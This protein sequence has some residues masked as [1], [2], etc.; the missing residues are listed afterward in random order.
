MKILNTDNKTDLLKSIFWQYDSAEKLKSLITQKQAYYDKALTAFW[1]NWYKNVF[2]LNTADT[3]GL[4]LWGFILNLPRQIK[5]K[6]GNVATLNDEQYRILLKGQFLKFKSGGTVPEINEYLKA[7]FGNLGEIYV[8]DNLD[9]SLTLFIGF[10]PPDWLLWLLENID[11]IP[12]PAGVELKFNI[13]PQNTLGFNGSGLETFNNGTFYYNYADDASET[14]NKIQFTINAPQSAEVS[15]NGVLLPYQNGYYSYLPLNT[16]YTLTV[17]RAGYQPYSVSGT[18]TTDMLFNV[19]D[20]QLRVYPQESTIKIDGVTVQTATALG[21][22]YR[23][24]Y[25]EKTSITVNYEASATNYGTKQGTQVLTVNEPN[26]LIELAASTSGI[27]WQ[28]DNIRTSGNGIDDLTSW[29]CDLGGTYKIDLQGEGGLFND[30]RNNTYT[31]GGGSVSFNLNLQIGQVLSF[32]KIN[33]GFTSGTVGFITYNFVD[34]F[35]GGAG[36][37]C[38]LDGNLIAVSGGG[39]G[40]KTGGTGGTDWYAGYGGGGYRYGTAV[41]ISAYSVKGFGILDE[42]NSNNA[43][44]NNDGGTIVIYPYVA[45]MYN[46]PCG[47]TGGSG[48]LSASLTNP[49]TQAAVNYADGKITISAEVA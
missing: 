29:T 35:H 4:N 8:L 19:Y 12:R 16:A 44:E 2:D 11:F 34:L 23:G 27:V 49:Q 17:S 30:S 13:V 15:L 45:P 26:A 36:I 24:F 31:A 33:G 32:K 22:V 42:A 18:A 7:A 3:F 25:S 1:Q 43:P 28:L 47:G 38:Y 37:A 41:G 14:E 21:Y 6:S 48:Y 46:V 9:M 10:E 40:I 5:S 20:Y 39:A